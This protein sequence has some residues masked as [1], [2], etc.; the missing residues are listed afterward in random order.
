MPMAQAGSEHVSFFGRKGCPAGDTLGGDSRKSET[1]DSGSN[2]RLGTSNQEV[3]RRN[4]AH[5]SHC[6]LQPFQFAL[7]VEI[8]Q[9]V[10]VHVV[11]EKL[12]R[13]NLCAAPLTYCRLIHQIVIMNMR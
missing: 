12:C 8:F 2:L 9:L 3:R 13:V 6:V 11:R 10:A 5:S 1:G 4:L 7:E